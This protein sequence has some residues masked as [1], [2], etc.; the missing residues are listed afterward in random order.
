MSNIEP[1]TI[2]VIELCLFESISKLG[3]LYVENSTEIIVNIAVTYGKYSG[4]TK[5]TFF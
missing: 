2:A 3:C 4:H 1:V 5:G